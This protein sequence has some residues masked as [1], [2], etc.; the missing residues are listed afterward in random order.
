MDPGYI[1]ALMGL[2]GVTIGGF[3][4]FATS[5]VTQ[6]AQLHERNAEIER[7]RR[8]EL[9]SEFIAEASRLYGDAL[10]H[11]KDD[12]TGLVQLYAFVAKM[13]LVASRDVVM[14][15]ELAMDTIIETYLTPNRTLRDLRG[16]AQR[17]EINFLRE[18]A[19]VSRQDLN[20]V[21]RRPSLA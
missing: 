15:A 1:S 6:Q 13:R 17:G 8:N 12:I 14:A 21:G 4:T 20:N 19:D 3:T 2:G 10:A 18:F 5:Y 16:A 11:Q 9:F 7:R